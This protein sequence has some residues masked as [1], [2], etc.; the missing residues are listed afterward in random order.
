MT[1]L[2][3]KFAKD[4]DDM[5]DVVNNIKK[6]RPIGEN[7][8]SGILISTMIPLLQDVTE[9]L[10]SGEIDEVLNC[11]GNAFRKFSKPKVEND[12]TSK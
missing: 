6:D 3:T 2:E 1:D 5:V 11:F 9:K 12:K 10:D 8:M 4:I 7:E